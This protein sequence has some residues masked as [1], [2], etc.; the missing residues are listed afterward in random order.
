MLTSDRTSKSVLTTHLNKHL[1][2]IADINNMPLKLTT[3]LYEQLT[4]ETLKWVI[5]TNALV[6]NWSPLTSFSNNGQAK[7]TTDSTQ[8]YDIFL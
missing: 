5:L 7:L 2:S 1:Q 8:S 4:A 6:D 3:D